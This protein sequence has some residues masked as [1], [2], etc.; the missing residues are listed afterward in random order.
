M[1]CY[2]NGGGSSSSSGSSGGDLRS[3]TLVALKTLAEDLGVTV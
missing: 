3:L 2:A 1:G